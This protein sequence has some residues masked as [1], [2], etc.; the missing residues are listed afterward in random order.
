M[1]DDCRCSARK[2]AGPSDLWE[3]WLAG[4]QECFACVEVS[5]TREVEFAGS[6]GRGSGG[7]GHEGD[8]SETGGTGEEGFAG[9]LAAKGKIS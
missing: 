5:Q 2:N 1:A 3:V 6:E 7:E 8:G 9:E 4:W